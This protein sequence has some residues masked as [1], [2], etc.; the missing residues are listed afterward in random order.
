MF[1]VAT[2][3]SSLL[4]SHDVTSC[5]MR[6]LNNVIAGSG[7]YGIVDDVWMAARVGGNSRILRTHPPGMCAAV[8]RAVCRAVLSFENNQCNIIQYDTST[9]FCAG[10]H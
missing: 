2:L 5:S 4:F 10:T 3:L 9:G 7:K 8:C 6:N 1:F